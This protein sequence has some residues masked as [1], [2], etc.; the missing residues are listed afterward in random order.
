MNFKVQR[1][2]ASAGKIL[3][4]VSFHHYIHMFSICTVV[5]ND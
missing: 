5:R 3:S 1:N 4:L 2:S